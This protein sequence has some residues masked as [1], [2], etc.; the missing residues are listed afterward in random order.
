M[1]K[2]C[3][4]CGITDEIIPIIFING[5]CKKCIRIQCFQMISDG[6]FQQTIEQDIQYA[7]CMLQVAKEFKER[8]PHEYQKMAEKV[9]QN[10]EEYM[11]L[12]LW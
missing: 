5:V 12:L 10:F 3:L 7:E 9:R 1:A 8:N 2:Q 4:Y 11:E 6:L